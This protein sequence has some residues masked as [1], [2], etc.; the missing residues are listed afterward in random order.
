MAR[1]QPI[2]FVDADANRNE[3][4]LDRKRKDKKVSR[5]DWRSESEPGGRA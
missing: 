5:E 3:N 1:A 2:F 4:A